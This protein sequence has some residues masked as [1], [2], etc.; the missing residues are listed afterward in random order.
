MIQVTSEAVGAGTC[1]WCRK[2][3]ETV[4][5]VSFADKSFTGPM[6]KADLLRAV[7]MK[8][9]PPATQ[10]VRPNGAPAPTSALVK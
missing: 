8:C 2:D 10:P 9:P 4:Y 3:K 1:G 5:T 6:C 7:E